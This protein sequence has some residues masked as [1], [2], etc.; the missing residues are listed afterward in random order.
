MTQ[1]DIHQKLMGIYVPSIIESVSQKMNISFEDAIK[2]F[3]VSKLYELYNNEETKLW[4]LSHVKIASMLHE[5]ITKGE[6]DF[7]DG[8]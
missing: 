3:Y 4:H 2:L 8:G 7:P 1:S 6:I 5:E